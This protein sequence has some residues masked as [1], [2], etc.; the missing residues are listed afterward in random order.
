[1]LSRLYPILDAS[2]LPEGGPARRSRLNDLA[3]ELLAAG[4]TIIQY[5]SKFGTGNE[6]LADA[7]IL[8]EEA[9][10]GS[11]ALILNDY[12]LLAV[13]AEF[14]GVH[15]GQQDMAAEEARAILGSGT[16]LG[17]STHNSD[18]LAIADRSSADYLAIGPIF[19]TVSK[20]NPDPVVGLEGLRRARG[21]TRKPLVAIG[22]ITVE[23]CASVIEAGADSVAVI[24]GLFA[25][26]FGRPPGKIAS[27]FF[28]ELR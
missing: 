20:E 14:D 10:R 4:V 23:N 3:G 1:M 21:S 27:D 6:I 24:A 5:R 17:L 25:D 8:R 15:L 16:I 12:P 18:Q 26:A 28:A 11:C 19:S 9:P 2:L 7:A 13:A 22:G